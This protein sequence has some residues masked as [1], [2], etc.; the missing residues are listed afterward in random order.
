MEGRRAGERR[1]HRPDETLQGALGIGIIRIAAPA[2]ANAERQR[3]R[4]LV[5][6]AGL[7]P[8]TFYVGLGCAARHTAHGQLHAECVLAV[9]A[10]ANRHGNRMPLAPTE[11]AFK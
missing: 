6:E 8:G 4:R 2:S 10:P 9:D 11:C 5:I 7:Q 3:A 1:A